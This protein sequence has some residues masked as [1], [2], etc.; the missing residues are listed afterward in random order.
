V[1][2][3]EISVASV[4]LATRDISTQDRLQ[5]VWPGVQARMSTNSKPAWLSRTA[6]RKL[7][8]RW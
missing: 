8:S 7:Q 2:Y 3:A 1:S 5:G 4:C 6:R